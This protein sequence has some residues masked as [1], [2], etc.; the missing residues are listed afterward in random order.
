MVR[1]QAQRILV[2][3]PHLMPDS[4]LVA[5][6]PMIDPVMVWVVETGIEAAVA[7]NSRIA[8]AVSAQKPPMGESFVIF[9][10][11]VLTMRQ[12]PKAVPRP[13]AAWQ[14]RMIHSVRPSV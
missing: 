1:I 9:M 6:T 14:A 2:A 7:E 10:P 11:I 3:T 5:P 8:P 4:R 13:I 12:P